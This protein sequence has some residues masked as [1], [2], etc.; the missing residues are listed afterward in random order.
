MTF[1]AT[2]FTP[3]ASLAGGALIGLAA[4]LLMLTLGRIAGLSGILGGLLPAV[5][6]AGDRGWRAA[7]LGGAIAA[8]VLI[9]LATGWRPAVTVEAGPLLIVASGLLVGIGVGIGSGCTS[10]HGVCGLARFSRR[11]LVATLVF[12]ATTALTVF[13][14]RHLIGA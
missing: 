14:T 9:F 5:G 1:A 12:M 6:D 11:S 8:P 2:T 3:L 4:V 13:V 7:F 10:G